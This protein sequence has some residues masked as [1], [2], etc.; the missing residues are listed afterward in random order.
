M[1]K[2]RFTT[3]L[4]S[5]FGDASDDNFSTDSPLLQ[6]EQRVAKKI[7]KVRT[8]SGKNF[9]SDLDTLF[10]D[11]LK[12][13]IV[14]K[15]KKLTKGLD[16]HDIS[17][18]KRTRRPMSGLDALIRQTSDQIIQEELRAAK[19]STPNPTKRVT[20]VCN[21]DNLSRLKKIARSEKRYLK[22]ILGRLVEEFVEGYTEEE[23]DQW[24]NE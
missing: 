21:E 10:A 3:G 23:F 12:D 11:A 1:S 19:T 4:E 7:R 9:T 2:K 17:T 15:A 16:E 24:L 14:E 5:V 8:K 20:F 18:K 6:R 22:D 13:T